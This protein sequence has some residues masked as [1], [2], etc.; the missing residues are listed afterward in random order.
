MKRFFGTV[1]P[2]T[3]PGGLVPVGV[4]A[5]GDGTPVPEPTGMSKSPGGQRRPNRAVRARGRGFGRIGAG[6]DERCAID[7]TI[8]WR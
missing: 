3:L 1:V 7:C 8:G 2:L 6:R 4:V 5:Q